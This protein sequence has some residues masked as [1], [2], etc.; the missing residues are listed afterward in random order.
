MKTIS[1]S[2]ASKSFGQFL[3]TV[4]REPVIVTKKNRPVAI[5]MSIQ[6]AE[7]FQAFQIAQ[8]IERGLADIEAG[9]YEE[10][11]PENTAKRIAEFKKRITTNQ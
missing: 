8:G 9:R 11:T 5:T 3:D 10:I 4:Q 2:V 7:A 6:D 1:A